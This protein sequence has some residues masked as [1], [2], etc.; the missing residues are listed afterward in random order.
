MSILSLHTLLCT[1]EIHSTFFFLLPKR[2]WD[3]TLGPDLLSLIVVGGG[4]FFCLLFKL[5]VWEDL[6]MHTASKGTHR[7]VCQVIP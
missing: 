1:L 5:Y 2:R 7:A 3:Q 4:G 6:C